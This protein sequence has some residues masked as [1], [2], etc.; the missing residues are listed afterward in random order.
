[1][2]FKKT[3][4]FILVNEEDFNFPVKF[5]GDVWVFHSKR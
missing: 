3:C 1:M 4:I 5:A 2:I